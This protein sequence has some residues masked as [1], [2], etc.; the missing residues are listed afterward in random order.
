MRVIARCVLA[1]VVMAVGCAAK[2]PRGLVATGRHGMVATIHPIATDAA[3]AVMRQG[4]NAIDAAVEAAL[5]L[6]VVDGHNSG[7]GGGC[8]MLVRRADGRERRAGD[9]AGEG[10]AGH[11]HSRRE[12]GYEAVADGGAG[13]R[14]A[15]VA[16]RVSV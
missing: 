13:V 12:G 7:I 14:R 9:G 15:G 16:G 6:G 3:V 4:G 8:F 2:P 10:D 1:I 11:V 5:M